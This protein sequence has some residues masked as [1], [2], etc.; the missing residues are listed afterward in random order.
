MIVASTISIGRCTAGPKP[1]AG[2]SDGN[3]IPPSHYE[4]APFN[5]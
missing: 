5:Q 4:R 2:S 1:V 3:P